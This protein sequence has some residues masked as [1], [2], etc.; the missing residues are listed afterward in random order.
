M[1][2]FGLA[3]FFA[4]VEADIVA[5]LILVLIPTLMLVK[6]DREIALLD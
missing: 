4:V 1:R 5:R 3:L 6:G 2:D